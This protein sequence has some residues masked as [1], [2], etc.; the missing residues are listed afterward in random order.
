MAFTARGIDLVMLARVASPRRPLSAANEGGNEKEKVL[1]EG[2][3]AFQK[4][5]SRLGGF[6]RRRRRL[7]KCLRRSGNFRAF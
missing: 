1:S 7:R 4:T 3:G 2:G 5:S 6:L